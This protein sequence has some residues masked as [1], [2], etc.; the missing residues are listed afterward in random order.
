MH[1]SPVERLETRLAYGVAQAPRLAWY[2]GHGLALRRLA[3]RY[4]AQRRPS[5]SRLP[6]PSERALTRDLAAL[7]ARDLANVEAGLYPVPEREDGALA[8]RLEAS[9]LFFDDLP[10]VARR[11]GEVQGQEVFDEGLGD[12]LPRYYRQN[13]HFQTD[14]WLSE[15]SAKL[16]DIQVETLFGGAANAMRRQALVPVAQHLRGRDQRRLQFLDIACGTGRFLREVKRAYPAMPVTGLDLSESYLAE[17]RRNLRDLGRTGFVMAPAEAMPFEDERFDVVSSVFLFHELPPK[18]RRAVAR[19]VR[20]VLK[21]GGL[22]VL[23]DSLQRGDTPGY[24]GLLE[25]FPEGFHEPYYKGYIDEDL[26]ALFAEAGMD[27]LSSETAWLSKVV[28]FR[29]PQG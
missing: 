6:P 15:R 1:L 27:H 2:L 12:G 23:V 16:Y 28:A 29:R 11:R 19:E 26:P 25:R 20:R 24:D 14:G 22:F 8:D 4:A 5:E 17:A 10:E 7:I 3:R 9:R 21:P 18:I 13:F